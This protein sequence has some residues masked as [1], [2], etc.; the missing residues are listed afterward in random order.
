MAEKILIL[1]GSGML[2]SMV[3]DYLSRHNEDITATVRNDNLKGKCSAKLPGVN[4]INFDV[5]EFIFSR[6]RYNY[7]KNYNCIINCIGITKPYCKDDNPSQI[8]N[9][10]FVNSLFPNYLAE[11]L[12]ESKTKIIQIATDCVYS[13]FKGDYSE[14]DKHDATD[15]YG[16]TKSLGESK[17]PNTVNLR[18]SIIGPEFERNTFLIEWFLNQQVNAT[19][20]GFENHEWNGITTLHFAKLVNGIISNNIQAG[21]LQHIVPKGKVTKFEM[22]KIF[23]KFYKRED[24]NINKHVA[25]VKI[26]RT[27]STLNNNINEKLW[28]AG[29]YDEIPD[30]EKMAEELS[31]FDY[32]F[33]N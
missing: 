32:K 29:G 26:D 17:Y 10:I 11:F 9:A 6:Q 14:I 33:K 12:Q 28:S 15:V 30:F 4:W 25:E 18:C 16:K 7:F 24:I 2:G 8:R 3:T 27:L 20:N 5:R 13:G 21:N 19:L 31:E 22:L 1:G 23:S